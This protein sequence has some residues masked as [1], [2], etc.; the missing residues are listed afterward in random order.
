MLELPM[1]LCAHALPVTVRLITALWSRAS[2]A[3]PSC[4]ARSRSCNPSSAVM[5]ARLFQC[6]F[7]QK[8]QSHTGLF[9]LLFEL[10]SKGVAVIRADVMAGRQ[11]CINRAG[12]LQRL[13][14]PA[15]YIALLPL[16]CLP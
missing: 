7:Q 2:T 9:H 5:T 6:F 11:L 13:I 1:P 14:G 10:R 12:D 4:S 8:G 3:A 16:L 15:Q